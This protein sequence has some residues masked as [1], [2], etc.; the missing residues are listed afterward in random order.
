MADHGLY[1]ISDVCEVAGAA[2]HAPDCLLTPFRLC[3]GHLEGVG[4]DADILIL[5]GL[6]INNDIPVVSQKQ[7][8]RPLVVMRTCFICLVSTTHPRAVKLIS[9]LVRFSVPR[10]IDMIIASID[11]SLVALERQVDINLPSQFML[12]GQLL[13]Q[14]PGEVVLKDVHHRRFSPLGSQRYSRGTRALPRGG[15]NDQDGPRTHDTCQLGPFAHAD[16]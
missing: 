2:W 3:S 8:S 6:D 5:S 4:S 14:G 11:D 10:C 16:R 7:V 9:S 12:Y 13:N 1:A 15:E